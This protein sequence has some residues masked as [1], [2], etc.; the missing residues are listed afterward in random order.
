VLPLGNFRSSPGHC[1]DAM[2]ADTKATSRTGTCMRGAAGG[3]A[4]QQIL[5]TSPQQGPLTGGVLTHHRASRPGA[6]HHMQLQP[7]QLL[8][9]L[10]S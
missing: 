10:G 9:N 8:P 1:L 7:C 6:A 4:V 5:Q 3:L 2:W